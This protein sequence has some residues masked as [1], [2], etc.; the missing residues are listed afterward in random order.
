MRVYGPGD[1]PITPELLAQ[2]GPLNSLAATVHDTAAAKGFYE[3]GRR[4]FGEVLMLVV[5][6]LAEALEEYRNGHG[7]NEV[8]ENLLDISG[9]ETKPIPYGSSNISCPKPEGIPI[10]LADAL[11][12]IL[13]ICGAYG[14]DIDTAVRLKMAYNLTRPHKHGKVC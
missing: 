4:N 9:T 10:E 3:G 12:R 14:I 1:L 11:I 5:S 8:Y 2:E 6:E 7:P 13:D